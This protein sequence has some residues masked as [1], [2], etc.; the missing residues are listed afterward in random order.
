MATVVLALSAEVPVPKE[1]TVATVLSV[2]ETP[3]AHASTA[4]TNHP[5]QMGTKQLLQI[6]NRLPEKA[7][8]FVFRCAQASRLQK[9]ARVRRRPACGQFGTNCLAMPILSGYAGVPAC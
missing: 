5:I 1:Q 7:A 2:T 6:Q 8:D 9:N 3:T 4:D